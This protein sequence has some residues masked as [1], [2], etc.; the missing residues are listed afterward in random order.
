MVERLREQVRGEPERPAADDRGH[1]VARQVAAEQVGRPRGQRGRQQ[2]ERVVRPERPGQRGQRRQQQRRPGDRR[3]PGEVEALRRVDA[4]GQ[5]RG[6]VPRQHLHPV[7]QRPGEEALIR[8]VAADHRV[9]RRAQPEAADQ[10]QRRRD[11]AEQHPE[12]LEASHG[13]SVW[14]RKRRGPRAGACRRGALRVIRWSYAGRAAALAAAPT[15]ARRFPVGPGALPYVR[16]PPL[17]VL[18][19]V[20]TDHL[21]SAVSRRYHRPRRSAT[22][23]SGVPEILRRGCLRTG[24]CASRRSAWGPSGP[25]TS[26]PARPIRRGARP[27]G[28]GP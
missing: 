22:R 26:S 17:A 19:L 23:I 20:R 16:R 5:E 2:R 18:S 3:R 28:R 24:N 9:L 14:P 15:L 12:R 25:G 1:D 11:V 13:R 4:V 21:L 7:D 8:A 6:L 27:A 10:E